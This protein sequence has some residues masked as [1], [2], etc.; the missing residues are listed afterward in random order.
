MSFPVDAYIKCLQTF[1]NQMDSKIEE[2]VFGN[3]IKNIFE[4]C[5]VTSFDKIDEHYHL[6]ITPPNEKMS[7]VEFFYQK[8][9]PFYVDDE[10]VFEIYPDK[11]TIVF[12]KVYDQVVSNNNS[13]VELDDNE[14]K[15]CTI[16]QIQK[17]WLVLFSL[18][19]TMPV[20]SIRWDGGM[21]V[22]KID[23]IE[24]TN[25]KNIRTLA[26]SSGIVPIDMNS[27]VLK[28]IR[29]ELDKQI[30]C[31]L[32]EKY[33]E[34]LLFWADIVGFEKED[35][36]YHLCLAKACKSECFSYVESNLTFRILPNEQK[37]EFPKA[38][39]QTEPKLVN[40]A[41]SIDKEYKLETIW[42]ETPYADW[43]GN[44]HY[45]PVCFLQKSENDNTINIHCIDDSIRNSDKTRVWAC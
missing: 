20:C 40:S 34:R 6:T 11:A 35:D 17:Q 5:Q 25:E 2:N 44:P 21:K 36:F 39:D 3:L 31:E 43:R 45:S 26:L 37:I 29:N 28:T 18:K 19:H 4:G 1:Q 24:N 27:L 16:W 42:G 23:C 33:F 9:K 41:S 14:G 22:F 38:M 10:L 30:G 13:N 32:F 8:S 7:K 15:L 12:K